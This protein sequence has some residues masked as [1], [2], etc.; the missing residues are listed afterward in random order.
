MSSFDSPLG[1]IS[2]MLRAG[3]VRLHIA[4]LAAEEAR[5]LPGFQPTAACVGIWEDLKG[6]DRMPLRSVRTPHA[7]RAFLSKLTILELLDDAAAARD[8]RWSLHGGD[9]EFWLGHS[10]KGVRASKIRAVDSDV[11]RSVAWAAFEGARP[12]Y[13]RFDY[14]ARG[15]PLLS[16]FVL[17]LP[18]RAEAGLGYLFCPTHFEPHMPVA[19]FRTGQSRSASIS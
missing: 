2:D 7:F 16:A 11:L 10:L 9:H 14:T 13:C 12:A 6:A 19:P 18:F 5:D 4:G 17:C 15:K 8:F 3:Q 1:P